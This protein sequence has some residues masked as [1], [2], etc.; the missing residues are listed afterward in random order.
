MWRDDVGGSARTPSGRSTYFPKTIRDTQGLSYR[1]LVSPRRRLRWPG[2]PDRLDLLLAAGVTTFGVAEML[3]GVV[4]GPTAATLLVAFLLGAPLAWRQ[5]HPAGVL[6]VVMAA[7]V[8][9]SLLGV[10]LYGFLAS[11]PACLVAVAGVA[12][13]KPRLEALAWLVIAYLVT[14]VTALQGPGS[15]LWGLFLVGGAWLA[16]RTLR[17]RQLMIVE[18]E[19]IRR[20][21]EATRDQ[22]ALAAVTQ[23]RSRIARELH[24]VVA[25]SV[26]VMVVQ[27]GAAA[28][29]LDNDKARALSAMEAVQDTGREALTELRRLL[30]VMRPDAPLELPLEPQ[31]TLDALDELT[32]RVRGAGV[33][34]TVR[35]T[36]AQRRLEPSVELAAYRILQEALTNV[37]KHAHARTAAVDVRYYPDLLELRVVDDGVG[38]GSKIAGGGHGL[39]GMR[40]RA[41]VFGG[42]LDAGPQDDGGYLVRAVLPLGSL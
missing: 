30:G 37:L 39:V 27:A 36:G 1:R 41:G 33:T 13:S 15:W 38:G 22:Q 14:A 26:S 20:E 16:G 2:P 35:R 18:L 32:E 6:T 10:S 3:S 28:R 24:D 19:R 31:P 4:R 8:L 34:V 25:H 21:L 23:E 42:S 12:A 9:A 5:R 17:S 29:V 7:F 40:E 11:V